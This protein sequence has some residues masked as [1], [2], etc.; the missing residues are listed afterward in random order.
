MEGKGREGE[1]GDGKME[2]TCGKG[3]ENGME[4]KTSLAPF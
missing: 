4:R 3:K 1:D 2:G